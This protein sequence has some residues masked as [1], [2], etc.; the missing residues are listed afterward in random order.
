MYLYVMNKNRKKHSLRKNLMR[1]DNATITKLLQREEQLEK[2]TNRLGN[3][4]IELKKREEK[5]SIVEKRLSQ[6]TFKDKKIIKR[7]LLPNI[8][9]IADKYKEGLTKKITPPEL[10]CKKYLDSLEIKYI[11]QH[12]IAYTESDF[13]IVDFF[14]PEKKLIVELDGKFHYE[15]EN[16]KKD[17]ARTVRLEKLNYKVERFKNS[18]V[19][20][21]D[22]FQ[23]DLIHLLVN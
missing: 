18:E 4:E 12:I 1:G 17:M 15:K 6:R 9:R 10:I 20:L 2:K 23:R 16:L 21:E 14:I 3:W 8:R 7:K 11:F 13:Y 22:T 5:V 19:Y